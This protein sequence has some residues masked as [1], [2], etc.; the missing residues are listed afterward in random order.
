MKSVVVGREVVWLQLLLSSVSIPDPSS[1]FPPRSAVVASV[2]ECDVIA[3]PSR[4]GD[5]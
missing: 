1:E 2:S 4:V 5:S 3:V